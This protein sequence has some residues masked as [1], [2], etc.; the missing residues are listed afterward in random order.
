MFVEVVRMEYE[1]VEEVKSALLPFVLDRSGE[2]WS[3]VHC[4]GGG[5]ALWLRDCVV[6]SCFVGW[7]EFVVERVIVWAS[8]APVGGR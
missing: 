8:S 5:L 6:C 1:V 7:A 3:L 4:V 2:G